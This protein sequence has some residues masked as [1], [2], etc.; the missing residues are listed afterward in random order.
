MGL[1]VRAAPVR[2]PSQL[3]AELIRFC[4]RAPSTRSCPSVTLLT[5]ENRCSSP[6][7][8]LSGGH[9][10]TSTWE[11]CSVSRASYPLYPIATRADRGNRPSSHCCLQ[12]DLRLAFPCNTSFTVTQD[13]SA[14]A[15]LHCG[16]TTNRKTKLAAQRA[17]ASRMTPTPELSSNQ[18]LN[19]P[20][21]C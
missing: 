17:I 11:S 6:S 5:S 2:P 16:L 19:R 10:D 18:P 12:P 9:V 14:A 21:G 15:L 3:Q 4:N 8:P 7:G 20:R 13:L 1:V